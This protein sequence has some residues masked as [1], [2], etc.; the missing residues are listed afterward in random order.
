MLN[1]GQCWSGVLQ[2]LDHLYELGERN[3][4]TAS[5]YVCPFVTCGSAAACSACSSNLLYATQQGNSEEV[6]G[7]WLKKTGLCKEF[8]IATKFGFDENFNIRGDSQFVRDEF[9]KSSKKLGVEQIDLFYQH[10]PDPK[11]PIEVTVGAMAELVKWVGYCATI[12]PCIADDDFVS[13]GDA[14]SILGCPRLVLPRSGEHTRF[15]R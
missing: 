1:A 15:I 13:R 6:I 8:F 2:I 14:L 9:E 7:K 10:R 3:I 12:R 5:I 4:A 11:T